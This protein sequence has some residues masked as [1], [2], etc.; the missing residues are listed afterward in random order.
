VRDISL[1]QKETNQLNQCRNMCWI[2]DSELANVPSP[3]LSFRDE[4]LNVRAGARASNEIFEFEGPC[5]FICVVCAYYLRPLLLY[6]M[7]YLQIDMVQIYIE[8]SGGVEDGGQE[9]VAVSDVDSSPN[10]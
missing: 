5:A 3:P 9:N 2:L 6:I 7:A 1:E 10:F 8:K 4:L